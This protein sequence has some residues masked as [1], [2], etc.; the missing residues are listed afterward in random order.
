MHHAWSTVTDVGES[1]SYIFLHI[2]KGQAYAVPKSA[3][4]D[5]AAIAEFLKL[6][7]RYRR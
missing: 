5:Q 4:A 1:D 3:F 7:E 2:N 6:C